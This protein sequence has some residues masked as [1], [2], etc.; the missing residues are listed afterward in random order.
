M[1][2]AFKGF[3][4]VSRRSRVFQKVSAGF[5]VVLG[6]YTCSQISS[7]KILVDIPEAF[8]GILK[9]FKTFQGV[10][11]GFRGIIEGCIDS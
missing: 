4:G 2:E 9:R 6:S 7:I 5:K 11:E 10:S 1:Y 3:E 8:Q